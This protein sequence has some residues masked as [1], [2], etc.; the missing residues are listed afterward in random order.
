VY[1][2]V[3]S[4]SAFNITF[5]TAEKIAQ[6][7]QII[8]LIAED[9]KNP[10]LPGMAQVDGAE[11]QDFLNL[12]SFGNLRVWG[13][14][15]CAELC[16]DFARMP[17]EKTKPLILSP[18]GFFRNEANLGFGQRCRRDWLRVAVW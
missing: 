11:H 4:S 8:D 18:D 3:A 17:L 10:L 12:G 2:L 7:Q 6:F 14:D 9:F 1:F 5:R 16:M 13:A 15:A